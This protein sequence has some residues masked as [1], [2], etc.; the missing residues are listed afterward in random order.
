LENKPS[1]NLNKYI[2][3]TGICSRRE[4]EKLITA[5]RVTINGKPTQLGNRVFDGDVVKIDGRP[6]KAKPKTLYIAFNKP[7]G[8][9]CT[10]D[11]KERNNIVKYINHPERLFPIGRLDKPSEGLIFLTND[12]DI[13]NKILRA[14]NNHEKDYVV[15]V[16]KPITDE[17]IKRMSNGIPILGTVTKKCKVT[18]ISTKV[19]QIVLTQGL[20]RQI[21]RMCEYL[22]YEVTKLKRTRIM[23]VNLDRLAMGQWRELTSEEL[24]E[25]NKMV[26]SSSKTEEASV[27]DKKI[28]KQSVKKPSRKPT[29]FNKKSAS[30]RKNSSKSKRS[31]GSKSRNRRR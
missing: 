18:K 25:I 16:D 11:S 8:I 24:S 21:R 30:F 3:S 10:T 23:N 9:V 4:A 29:N 13:V 20:N 27:D 31:S 6:L 26:A 7:V 12:G 22:G 19:F 15:T 17:F 2:S 14:G 28:K 5:G 1:I